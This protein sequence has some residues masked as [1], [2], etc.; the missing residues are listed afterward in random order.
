MKYT[1]LKN[2]LNFDFAISGRFLRPIMLS[3]IST[4]RSFWVNLK[5]FKLDSHFLFCAQAANHPNYHF[6]NTMHC[7]KRIGKWYI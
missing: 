4:Y 6:E 1:C 7:G 3:T 2:L 5:C